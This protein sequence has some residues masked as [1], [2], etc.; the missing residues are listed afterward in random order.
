[1]YASRYY[2]VYALLVSLL[3]ADKITKAVVVTVTQTISGLAP[4]TTSSA[5]PCLK[6]LNPDVA[7]VIDGIAIWPSGPT[8]V[9]APTSAL[10]NVRE[11]S[12]KER[13]AQSQPAQATPSQIFPNEQ[14]MQ[15]KTPRPLNNN[16]TLPFS[17]PNHQT[18]FFSTTQ[19]SIPADPIIAPL[20]HHKNKT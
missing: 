1:M 15:S 5:D 11:A 13:L 2:I 6:C 20:P 8:S 9:M 19:T 12:V 14:N 18:P 17:T 4:S 10:G 16:T 7:C 3:A